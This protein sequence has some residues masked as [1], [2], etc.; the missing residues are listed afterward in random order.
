MRFRMTAGVRY[1]RCLVTPLARQHTRQ[2]LDEHAAGGGVDLLDD[3]FDGRH[4]DF[5]LQATNDVDVVGA[6]FD[7]VGDF[8][9]RL[10]CRCVLDEQTDDL[11]PVELALGQADGVLGGYLDVGAAQGGGR[12]T[13][14]DV[15]EVQ[16]DRGA[17]D[18]GGL[19][20]MR[21]ACDENRVAALKTTCGEV[22]DDAA[23]QL[24]LNAVGAEDLGDNEEVRGSRLRCRLGKVWARRR[25]GRL[26]CL[27][28]WRRL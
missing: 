5:A 13:I 7:D 8:A 2:R 18:A 3:V 21:L 9:E 14:L 20:G 28:G 6:G 16:E 15:L 19:D 10:V 23:L 12:I 27:C 26:G 1:R 22:G 24:A 11:M 25:R 17:L 4:Q